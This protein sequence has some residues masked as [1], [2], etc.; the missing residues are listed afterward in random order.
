MYEHELT[1]FLVFVVMFLQTKRID[2]KIQEMF[3]TSTSKS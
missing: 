1:D 3:D 2:S